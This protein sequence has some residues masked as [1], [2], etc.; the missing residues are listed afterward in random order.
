M[1][2]VT[3]QLFTHMPLRGV[4]WAGVGGVV[5][6]ERERA[7]SHFVIAGYWLRTRKLGDLWLLLEWVRLGRRVRLVLVLR[8]W[9]CK[10]SLHLLLLLR[11]EKKAHTDVFVYKNH[12]T[13]RPTDMSTS[14]T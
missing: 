2:R 12:A 1:K 14:L 6:R 13:R 7:H 9:T 3:Q 5:Q 4:E 11:E 10:V 8:R